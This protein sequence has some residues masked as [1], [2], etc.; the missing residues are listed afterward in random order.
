MKIVSINAPKVR[1]VDGIMKGDV[2]DLNR[3]IAG[4]DEANGRNDDLRGYIYALRDL[5]RAHDSFAICGRENVDRAEAAVR[6]A[7]ARLTF[8]ELS[9]MR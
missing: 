6:N 2:I 1:D 9:L 5:Q 3:I 4:I 7:F 8:S